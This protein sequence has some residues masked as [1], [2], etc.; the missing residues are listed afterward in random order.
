VCR[1]LRARL[2]PPPLLVAV[3]VVVVGLLRL[4][5]TCG[6]RGWRVVAFYLRAWLR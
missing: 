2:Q 4:G 3:L 5:W 1:W 6:G